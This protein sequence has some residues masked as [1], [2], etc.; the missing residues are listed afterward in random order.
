ML[1]GLMYQLN[2]VGEEKFD[3]Y[4]GWFL[5]GRFTSRTFFLCVCLETH[6]C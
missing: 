5:L 4:Y 1:A 3:S 6:I 2:I